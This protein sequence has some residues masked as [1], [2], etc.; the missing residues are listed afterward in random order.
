MWIIIIGILIL[1]AVISVCIDE[2]SK[3]NLSKKLESQGYKISKKLDIP[4]IDEDN[5]P[6]CFMVDKENKKWFLTSYRAKTANAYDY[7]DIVDYR[8]I[9]RLKDSGTLSGERFSGAFSEFSSSNTKILDLVDLDKGNCEHISF[10]I[11]YAGKAQ[12]ANLY[13]K[14]VLYE[15]QE[16][17]FVTADRHDFVVPSQCIANARDFESLLFEILQERK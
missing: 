9:Y 14:F 3:S 2:L 1:A 4:N 13:K 7:S 16:G 10:K 17:G 11:T 6:F 5:K 15:S 8:I 12:E